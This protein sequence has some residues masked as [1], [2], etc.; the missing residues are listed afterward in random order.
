MGCRNMAHAAYKVCSKW[1]FWTSLGEGDVV[2]SDVPKGHLVVYVGEYRKRFVISL[3]LL[4]HPLFQALLDHAREVYG[5]TASSRLCIPCDE[6]IF[7]RVVQ[8]AKSQP[9]RQ[10]PICLRE[11]FC[12]SCGKI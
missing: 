4:K 3:T 12:N 11:F 2:P 5:F 7:L 1:S 8:C 6:T 10:L 9:C